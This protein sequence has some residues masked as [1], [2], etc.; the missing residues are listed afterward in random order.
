MENNVLHDNI[1]K[2]LIRDRY[3]DDNVEEAYVSK[4]SISCP[5]FK[6][7]I[8]V[9][10]I[11]GVYFIYVMGVKVGYRTNINRSFY[12]CLNNQINFFLLK[13]W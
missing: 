13:M 5:V 10:S 9:D 7:P 2:H 12:I 11:F 6:S 8:T 3:I 4:R 1:R